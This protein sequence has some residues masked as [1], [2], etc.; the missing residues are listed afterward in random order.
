MRRRNCWRASP[1]PRRPTSSAGWAAAPS[2]SAPESASRLLIRIKFLAGAGP[3][4]WSRIAPRK[5]RIPIMSLYTLGLNHAT[6]PLEVRERV[7][8][9]PDALL[10]ALRDLVGARRVKE[11]AILSTCNRTEVY[12]RGD[13]PAAMT[14]WLA[15]FHN[16][17]A[18]SLAPYVYTL[19]REKAVTHAF[20]VASGL[21]S[22]VLG[23]R[24]SWD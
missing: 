2:S 12:F 10:D 7:V 8:F 22:V 14:N 19:P 11:A 21:D 5:L 18:R 13:D 4:G 23:S 6:A 9:S 20:R 3:V 17:P 15:G 16:L 24:R 1:R